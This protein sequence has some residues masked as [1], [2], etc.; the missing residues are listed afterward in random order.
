[1]DHKIGS[2]PL[3]IFEHDVVHRTDLAVLGGYNHAAKSVDG[4]VDVADF[5]EFARQCE[6]FVDVASDYKCDFILFP[7]LFSM[8]LLSFLKA[9]RPGLAVR[10]LAEQTPGYLE[11][12]SRLALRYDVNIIG[13][14]IFAVEH[15]RLYNVAYLFHRNGGIDK[16]YKLHVTPNERRWW[17]VVPGN[18][19]EVF[20]T[21]KGKVSI[22]IC[23]DIEFPEVSRIAVDRGARILFVPYC[24]DGTVNFSITQNGTPTWLAT[25]ADVVLLRMAASGPTAFA[26]SSCGTW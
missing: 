8:Q 22:Q 10:R 25:E 23:Y 21:D 11:L 20:N 5:D 14:S 12:L 13:G 7:E 26:T 9:E 17:G 4:A 2:L 3:V 15:E 6:Y 1:M 24:T 18:R 16:Q 19:L